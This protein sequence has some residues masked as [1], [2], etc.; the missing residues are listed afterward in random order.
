[1]HTPALPHLP[2]H[3]PHVVDDA[4]HVARVAAHAVAHELDRAV[5]LM[6]R[7]LSVDID[8]TGAMLDEDPDS[9]D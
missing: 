6:L 5:D 4:E 8:L 1:M 7:P 3:V 9:W 2:H